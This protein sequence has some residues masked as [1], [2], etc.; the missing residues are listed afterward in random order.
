M[1]P[2]R[3]LARPAVTNSSASS[4]G[5]TNVARSTPASAI[6]PSPAWRPPY[7]ARSSVLPVADWKATPA[8]P[9]S[10]AGSMKHH[11]PYGSQ[12]SAES[13]RKMR[14]PMPRPLARRSALAGVA[15]REEYECHARA[16]RRVAHR[17][18]DVLER[19]ALAG[20]LVQD[21]L[22]L[23]V[24]DRAGLD[25]LVLARHAALRSR[26]ETRGDGLRRVAEDQ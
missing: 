18:L 21:R 2:M 10:C 15:A 6:A 19:P 14:A 11:T 9:A 23:L 17:E 12:T 3:A 25:H 13:A 26:S 5:R 8:L 24:A 16:L 1:P 22:E 20:P 4:A 7:I